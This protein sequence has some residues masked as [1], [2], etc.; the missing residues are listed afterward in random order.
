MNKEE[1]KLFV[2][3]DAVKKEK[4][5]IKKTRDCFH[6]VLGV[7]PDSVDISKGRQTTSYF[8]EDFVGYSCTLDGAEFYAGEI[9]HDGGNAVINAVYQT[10][11]IK[12]YKKR[13][14]RKC[15][16]ESK[17]EFLRIRRPADIVV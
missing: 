11:T 12:T 4:E 14:F 17:Q 10:L 16:I 2:S 6:K 7:Y 13:Y 1:L 8:Y 5:K 15:K 9:Y 3:T